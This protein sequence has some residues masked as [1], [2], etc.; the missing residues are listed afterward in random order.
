MIERLGGRVSMMFNGLPAVIPHV[1]ARRLRE[2]AVASAARAKGIRE[3]A[4]FAEAGSWYGVFAPA[5]TLSA[6][7]AKLH[8][9]VVNMLKYPDVQQ[10]LVSEDADPIGNTPEQFA[11]QIKRDIT[12]WGNVARGSGI[13]AV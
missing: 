5:G 6:V 11:V 10:R 3:I 13:P 2:I 9:E 4:T 12:K 8:S 7:I 1:K